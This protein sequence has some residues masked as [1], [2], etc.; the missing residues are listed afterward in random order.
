M[1]FENK[2]DY[3]VGS[4]FFD[5]A[6]DR[7]EEFEDVGQ[8]EIMLLE[9]NNMLIFKLRESHNTITVTNEKRKVIEIMTSC[10]HLNDC[11]QIIIDEIKKIK[12]DA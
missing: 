2:I 10:E 5:W 7:I 11:R 3:S 6:I 12:G 9:N 4:K 1:N 8:K